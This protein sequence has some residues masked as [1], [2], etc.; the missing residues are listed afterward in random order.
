MFSRI[1]HVQGPVENHALMPKTIFV[2]K[3]GTANF[4]KREQGSIST[5]RVKCTTSDLAVLTIRC[6]I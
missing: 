2:K 1:S 6:L 3:G 4:N 5:C